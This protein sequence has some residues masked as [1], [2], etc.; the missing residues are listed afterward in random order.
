[1]NM[2]QWDYRA[3]LAIAEACMR[4]RVPFYWRSPG[5]MLIAGTGLGDVLQILAEQGL[6][7]IGLEGFEM[8]PPDI[9]PR[10]DLIYDAE[11]SGSDARTFSAE[12]PSHVWVDIVLEM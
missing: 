3:A 8:V 1:M 2:E 4:L 7:A 5:T 12:W 9:T 11:R 10:L 6:P